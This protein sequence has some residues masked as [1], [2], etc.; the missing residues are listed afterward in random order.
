MLVD[1][2]EAFEWLDNSKHGTRQVKHESSQ[3]LRVKICVKFHLN[4]HINV[5][6]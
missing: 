1:V 2:K 5:R 4:R 3:S 6:I